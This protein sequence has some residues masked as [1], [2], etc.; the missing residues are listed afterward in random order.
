MTYFPQVQRIWFFSPK[1]RHESRVLNKSYVNKLY[2][3]QSVFNNF[4]EDK[5]LK[6]CSFI[7]FQDSCLVDSISNVQIDTSRFDD[8]PW[9]DDME[10][11]AKILIVQAKDVR[12]EIAAYAKRDRLCHSNIKDM[13]RRAQ[14]EKLAARLF[15]QSF[16]NHERKS[17]YAQRLDCSDSLYTACTQL[18]PKWLGCRFLEEW[19]RKKQGAIVWR[20]HETGLLGTKSMTAILLPPMALCHAGE[21]VIL[22]HK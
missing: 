19:S 6:Y 9:L 15:N 22:W 10:K 2:D 11:A 17:M 7:P 3:Q 4:F 8:M 5:A 1:F 14:W 13:I 12:F 20:L 21:V 18:D 16:D